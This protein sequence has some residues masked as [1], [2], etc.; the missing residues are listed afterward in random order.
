[1]NKVMKINFASL[2]SL[3]SEQNKQMKEAIK[4]YHVFK[5]LDKTKGDEKSRFDILI[6]D[7]YQ[8]FDL[9]SAKDVEL[10]LSELEQLIG[11]VRNFKSNL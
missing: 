2:T 1:M 10:S 8:Q 5:S 6:E 3:N 7:L 9:K 4:Q 11:L